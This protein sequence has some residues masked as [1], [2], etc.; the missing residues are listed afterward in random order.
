MEGVVKCIGKPFDTF[1]I[2][3]YM[4]QVNALPPFICSLASEHAI[5]KFQEIRRH[6]TSLAINFWS[7]LMSV[8]WW[9]HKHG[10]E[11]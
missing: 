6:W 11:K 10:K 8:Y 1:Y 5:R 9:K 4:K 2:Q 3:N 7:V